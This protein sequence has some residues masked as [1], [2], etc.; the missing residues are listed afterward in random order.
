MSCSSSAEF[1]SELIEMW[2]KSVVIFL[3]CLNGF[4]KIGDCLECKNDPTKTIL[5]R[6][7]Y[8]DGSYSVIDLRS[9]G[10]ERLKI[11][12]DLKDRDY[13]IASKS[14]IQKHSKF[15]EN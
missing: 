2:F 4:I 13:M 6:G 14:S 10:N 11:H 12:E 8:D 3:L 1:F 7:P 9:C 15:I 5:W